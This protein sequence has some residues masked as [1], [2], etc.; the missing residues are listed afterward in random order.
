MSK[1]EPTGAAGRDGRR[2]ALHRN[3]Y[4]DLSFDELESSPTFT[5]EMAKEFFPV[6]REEPIDTMGG[7]VVIE[8]AYPGWQAGGEHY[9]AVPDT[10]EE[11]SL[12]LI[13]GIEAGAAAVHVHPRNEERRPQWESPELLAEVLDPVFEACGEVI[14]TSQTWMTG[15][16]ADY[17]TATEKLLRMG[18]GNKYCQGS[19]V[20]P[21]GLFGAGTY[22]SPSAITEGV[23]F[24]QENGVKPV[25]QLYD[26]HVLYD[27]KHRLFEKGE[28][29][30]DSHMLN[31]YLGAHHSQTTNNDPWS[32]LNVISSIYNARE[33]IDDAI[34]GVNPG[35]RNWLPTLVLGLLAGA[36]VVRV[37][38][39]DTY[40]RYPHRNEVIQDNTEIIE[41]AVQFAELLGREVITDPDQARDFLGMEYTSPR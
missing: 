8:C 29:E 36:N 28:V 14:T 35:G 2:D 40:W 26:T 31:L 19:V 25:F 16:H 20:L 10:L 33:T 38:I 22:H 13:E 5:P 21:M 24:F 32:Y 6:H 17:V 7:P 1:K 12:G 41:L 3:L 9:P 27:L 18:D 11:Q 37:G 39:E 30:E 34:V 4:D 15:P 23:R